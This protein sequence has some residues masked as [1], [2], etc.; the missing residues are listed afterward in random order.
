MLHQV[1]TVT[2][3]WTVQIALEVLSVTEKHNNLTTTEPYQ[4]SPPV[5]VH[6]GVLGSEQVESQPLQCAAVSKVRF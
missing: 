6:F 5:H 1:Y 2:Q 4:S 3:F